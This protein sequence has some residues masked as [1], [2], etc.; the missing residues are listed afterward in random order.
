MIFARWPLMVIVFVLTQ[1]CIKKKQESKLKSALLQSNSR[2]VLLFTDLMGVPL[3]NPKWYGVCFLWSELDKKEKL[4]LR[5]S[6][7]ETS[8]L[9]VAEFFTKYNSNLL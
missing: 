4:K 5:N 2:E 9:N 1:G 3:K 7:S 8:T 6:M